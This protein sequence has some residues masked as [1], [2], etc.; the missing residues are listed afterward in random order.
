MF[1]LPWLYLPSYGIISFNATLVLFVQLTAVS[2]MSLANL[3]TSLVDLIQFLQG[4]E[5]L[6]L[7]LP[8]IAAAIYNIAV[9]V[10]ILAQTTSGNVLVARL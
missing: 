7:R 8:L 5:G 10:R 6:R 2:L 9:C 1:Y 4:S 3:P